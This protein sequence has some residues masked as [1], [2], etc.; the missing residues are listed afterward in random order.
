MSLYGIIGYIPHTV[1]FTL[2]IHVFYNWKLVPLNFLHLFLAPHN[3]ILYDNHLFVLCIYN[4]FQFFNVCSFVLSFQIPHIG[5][6]LE[7]LS[8]SVWLI[9]L[10][11]APLGLSM[12]FQ[13]VE[14]HLFVASIP[15]C[16]Y[17]TSLPIHVN[18]H[19]LFSC[20]DY[21]KQCCCECW[22]ACIFSNQ[23]FF[24]FFNE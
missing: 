17:T 6:I 24:F 18:G 22:G 7:H 2:R 12:L 8:S 11:I 4:L 21:Y 15:L 23:Q 20:L 13:M 3:P 16:I 1:P 9:S 14:F 5:E 10:H 19:R